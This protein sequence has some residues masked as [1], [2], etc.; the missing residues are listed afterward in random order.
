MLGTLN[1]LKIYLICIVSHHEYNKII[2]IDMVSTE[3]NITA[4]CDFNNNKGRNEGEIY[5]SY[6]F[7]TRV[8]F[9][10]N[11]FHV[12]QQ[13]KLNYREYR[14]VLRPNYM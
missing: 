3:K 1:S 2:I 6:K 10:F 12:I 4:S 11:S 5:S 9:L 14:L 7:F 8:E 13:K